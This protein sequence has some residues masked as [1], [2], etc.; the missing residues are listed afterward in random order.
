MDIYR[1]THDGGWDLVPEGRPLEGNRDYRIVFDLAGELDAVMAS[2]AGAMCTVGPE[3]RDATVN[4]GNFVGKTRLG[5]REL[6]VRHHGKLDDASF[7]Q[8]LR[9]I[10]SASAGLPFDFNRPTYLPFDRTRRHPEPVL[11][12]KFAYVRHIMTRAGKGDSFPA[13]FLRIRSQPHRRMEKEWLNLDVSRARRVEPQTILAVVQHP[14]DLVH[15]PAGSRAAKG[16][17][18]RKLRGHFPATAWTWE[19]VHSYD[20]PENRFVKHL[21]EGV[22]DI[23][24]QFRGL[25]TRRETH[26]LD[27]TV[28]LDAIQME[29]TLRELL[30][31]PFLQDVGD[32]NH[33]PLSSSVLQGRSGYREMLGHF[34]RLSLATGYPIDDESL[35][36]MIEAKDIATLYEYWCFF[37]LVAAVSA[38]LGKPKRADRAATTDDRREL[39]GTLRVEWQDGTVLYYQRSYYALKGSYSV[40]LRPDYVLAT[41][42]ESHVFDAKFKLNR[43]GHG[44][45]K[46]T[47]ADHL[48]DAKNVDIYK[49][50]TYRDA[51]PETVSATVLYPG[52]VACFYEDVS[53]AAGAKSGAMHRELREMKNVNG[54]GAI[55]LAPGGETMQSDVLAGMVDLV[56]TGGADT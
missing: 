16:R 52:D 26:F 39:G 4:F 1:R 22:L 10:D 20:T 46:V 12:H 49:M 35:R 44:D 7:R 45:G 36:M 55:P 13:S 32:L 5:E 25:M 3:R 14:H 33:L 42:G 43:L 17:L 27:T 29:Q 21:L 56:L 50:H 30:R 41:G 38:A 18:A 23:V 11:Y 6:E 24:R 48:R 31:S 19:P 51:L 28:E 8:M 2:P 34:S 15:L 9:D 47:E 54:V 40:T 37:E 53:G